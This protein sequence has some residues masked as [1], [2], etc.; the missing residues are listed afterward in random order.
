MRK[1]A[2]TLAAISILAM[3]FGYASST[4]A[5][6]ADTPLPS[7]STGGPVFHVY[8]A[9]GVI[10]NNNLETAVICTNLSSGAANIGLEVFDKTGALQNTIGLPN[11]EAT[12]VA[13]G[14]TVTF[15]TSGIAVLAEDVSI[16]GLPS[17]RNGS[18]RVVAS[19]KDISCTAMIADEVHIVE[20]PL[21]SS[22]PPPTVVNL[23]LIRLP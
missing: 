2:K 23:P 7:F 4:Q 18:G 8:T 17:L 6:P 21:V 5:G 10:K 11:G 9:V 15:A 19:T 13:V 16:S 20:N 14:G 22:D 12:G 1:T 3:A